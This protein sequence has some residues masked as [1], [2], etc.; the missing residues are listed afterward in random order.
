M[1]LFWALLNR[2]KEKEKEKEITKCGGLTIATNSPRKDRIY[3]SSPL[4]LGCA[5][6]Y[7]DQ[8][9]TVKVLLWRFLM[10]PLRSPPFP[11]SP[12]SRNWSIWAHWLINTP[13]VVPLGSGMPV[14]LPKVLLDMCFTGVQLLGMWLSCYYHRHFLP[15]HS[16]SWY[17]SSR[18]TCLQSTVIS[19][20]GLCCWEQWR[21]ASFYRTLLLVSKGMEKHL[22]W[23]LPGFQFKRNVRD[24][25]SKSGFC[26]LIPSQDSCM[27]PNLFLLQTS[28][29]K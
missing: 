18:L 15:W 24:S 6:D 11:W 9:N 5:C 2:Q 28:H 23:G 3:F 17:K 13:A 29:L 19:S 12:S 14:S 21:R 8:E 16:H 4:Y 27:Q 26:L 7:F 20:C 10:S 22:C 25:S 1:P